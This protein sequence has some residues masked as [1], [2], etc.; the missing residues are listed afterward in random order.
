MNVKA[1]S[2]KMAFSSRD[3]GVSLADVTK[4]C[5]KVTTR[6]LKALVHSLRRGI[7]DSVPRMGDGIVY[8][9]LNLNSVIQVS[10]LKVDEG[11]GDFL[12]GNSSGVL[13]RE[14][15]FATVCLR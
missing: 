5:L 2:Q 1:V 11:S 6:T 12:L 8:C 15:S 4:A 14:R 3:F 7:T 9:E 13:Q 10:H